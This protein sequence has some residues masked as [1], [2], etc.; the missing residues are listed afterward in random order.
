M[1]LLAR[2]KHGKPI[3][4][5]GRDVLIPG[6]SR[7]KASRM[8]NQA[9]RNRT[10]PVQR[11]L[12]AQAVVPRWP[13]LSSTTSKK[14]RRKAYITQH[15]MHRAS[16]GSTQT[17]G[18]A[19]LSDTLGKRAFGCCEASTKVLLF[20]SF[21]CN[22][23]P[24]SSFCKRVAPRHKEHLPKHQNRWE[25]GFSCSVHLSQAWYTTVS[26]VKQPRF[27]VPPHLSKKC[28]IGVSTSQ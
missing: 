28:L 14:Q 3:S 7:R 27:S 20:C 19:A 22:L 12:L 16:A 24:R 4:K 18:L 21:F 15:K 8:L 23:E 10:F 6:Q 25:A 2:W 11:S 13:A 17:T 5:N 26:H 1:L 9:P